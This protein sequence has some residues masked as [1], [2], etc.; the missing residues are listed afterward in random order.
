MTP[1]PILIAVVVLLVVIGA[2]A[3]WIAWCD[4]VLAGYRLA[5]G[6]DSDAERERAR[7]VVRRLHPEWSDNEPTIYFVAGPPRSG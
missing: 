5:M 4:G 2:I 6:W 7:E 3:V 1:V